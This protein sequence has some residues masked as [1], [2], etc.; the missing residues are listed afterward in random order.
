MNIASYLNEIPCPATRAAVQKIFEQIVADMVAN[1]ATFDAHTHECNGA[2]T[3]LYNC[4]TPDTTEG[5]AAVAATAAATFT[6][7]ITS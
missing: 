3:G 2:D 7:N 4:S 5:D 1:K 6:T